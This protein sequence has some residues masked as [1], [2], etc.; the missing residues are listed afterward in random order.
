MSPRRGVIA[1][2]AVFGAAAATIAVVGTGLGWWTGTSPGS[3]PARPLAVRTSLAPS[4]A[5]FG[6][7]T[8]AEI[9]VDLDTS[10]VA[11]GSVRVETDFAPYL[12]TGKPQVRRSRGGREETVTYRYTL[13]CVTNACLPPVGGAWPVQLAPVV[14]TATS[15]SRRLAITASWPLTSVSSRLRRADVSSVTPRFRHPAELSPADF[16]VSPTVLADLLTAAAGLL[17]AAAFLILALELAALARRRRGH[18]TLWPTPLARALALTRQ[19]ARSP[20]AAHR[21]EAL[22]LLAETLAS[23]GV[24]PLADVTGRVAWSHEPP[25]P[26]RALELAEQAETAGTET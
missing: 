6:D 13:Q 7:A 16:G 23:E 26:V 1:A 20:D 25:S 22:G 11:A 18:T 19:A 8:V 21:R 17:A 2:A 24:Q 5:F 14:V 15:G 10:L 3:A 9:A 12:Q 4:P